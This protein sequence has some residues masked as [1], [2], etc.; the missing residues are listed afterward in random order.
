MPE[1]VIGIDLGTTNSVLAYTPLD[2]DRPK[3]EVLPIPQIVAATVERMTTL[4]SFLYLAPEHE[5]GLSTAVERRRAAGGGRRGAAAQRR[6]AGAHRGR[7][8]ELAGPQQ[9][10][11]ASADLAVERAGG[12]AK[13]LAGHRIA[14]LSGTSGRRL[15]LRHARCAI[16]RAA[17]RAHGAGIV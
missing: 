16:C 9:G 11:S 13:D 14:A 15:E 3:V 10:R 4:P 12:G 17:R 7:G 5:H 1:Y 6:D 8:Q 2:A